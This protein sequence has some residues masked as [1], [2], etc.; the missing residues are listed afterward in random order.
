MNYE[1]RVGAFVRLGEFLSRFVVE[2]KLP[3]PGTIDVQCANLLEDA[4]QTSG[5]NNGWFTRPNVLFALKGLAKLLNEESLK[6]W[7]KN[8]PGLGG[9]TPVRRIGVIMAGNIPLVG[10]HDLLCVLITGNIFIGKMSSKDNLL[11]KTL[12]EILI[13]LESGLKPQVLFEE[14]R[15]QNFD[16]IIATGSDNSSRYFEYYFGKYPHIIRKNRISIAVLDGAETMQDIENLADDIFLYFGLG[17]RNVSKIYVPENYNFDLF[18]KTIEKYSHLKFHNK[19]MN[20][21]DYNKSIFQVNK[22]LHFDNGFV[23]LKEDENFVSPIAVIFYEVYKNICNLVKQ[24]G[25]NYVKVQCIVSNNEAIFNRVNFGHAQL[26]EVWEY[27][28]NADTV[29]L[30]MTLK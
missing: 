20:N 22:T 26:P 24:I 6:T 19:Y 1:K 18:F 16:A 17:C 3:A 25:E 12:C 5:I 30:L 9:Q 27:A 23:L 2:Q 4:I 13:L 11:L 8:Y 7:L 14:N 21:Y 29:K 10:F 28:D 15:L